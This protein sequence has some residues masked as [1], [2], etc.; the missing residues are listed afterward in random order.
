M[1]MMLMLIASAAAAGGVFAGAASS[2]IKIWD[3][4]KLKQPRSRVSAGSS[5]RTTPSRSS[6][7]RS[8]QSG[9][10]L[11]PPAETAAAAAAP[12]PRFSLKLRESC[13]PVGSGRRQHGVTALKVHQGTNRLLASCSDSC[14][15]VFDALR[16]ELGSLASFS[17]HQTGSFYVKADFS[18][19]GTHFVSGSTDEKLY[20]WQVDRPQDGPYTFGGHS[21]EVCDVAWCPDDF[22]QIASSSDDSSVRLWS[23]ARG[24]DGPQAPRR[25]QPPPARASVRT[26]PPSSAQKAGPSASDSVSARSPLAPVHGNRHR[27]AAASPAAE[28][29]AAKTPSSVPLQSAIDP[30]PMFGNQGTPA[31]VRT[32]TDGSTPG[33]LM[34]PQPTPRAAER[35]AE[36]TRE[37]PGSSSGGGG[38]PSTSSLKQVSIQGFLSVPANR[39]PPATRRRLSVPGQ[40]GQLSISSFFQDAADDGDRHGGAGSDPMET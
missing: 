25:L 13:P 32:M 31:A 30:S 34:W 11:G 20:I 21:G 16:P 2:V 40:P 27:L 29:P 7:R 36:A 22:F 5:S 28:T 15:Y 14:H 17:G 23:V 18:P 6:T 37:P 1:M 35:R 24:K 10:S 8:S 39:R 4:R 12:G 33:R 26:E 3:I 19:C 38:G 9:P